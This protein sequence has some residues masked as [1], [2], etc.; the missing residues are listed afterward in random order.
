VEGIQLPIADAGQISEEA[1]AGE[2]YSAVYPHAGGGGGC[3][4]HVNY[5]LNSDEAR[6]YQWLVG[7]LLLAI[8]K[9]RAYSKLRH[10]L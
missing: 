7:L 2:N 3:N 8:R 4:C 10:V 5:P 6:L 9:R 1:V